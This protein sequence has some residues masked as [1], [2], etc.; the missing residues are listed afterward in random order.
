MKPQAHVFFS[1]VGAN[2]EVSSCL[3]RRRIFTPISND[4]SM[5][6][7][8]FAIFPG[9]FGK[10]LITIITSRACAFLPSREYSHVSRRWWAISAWTRTPSTL[11]V[12]RSSRR[13]YFHSILHSSSRRTCQH[14]ELLVVCTA[15][16]I[17]RRI[18]SGQ[19]PRALLRVAVRREEG[20]QV[21]SWVSESVGGAEH[22]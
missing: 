11:I 18:E 15:H 19:Q 14:W 9:A 21:E 4:Q 8:I 16:R 20:G 7:S 17:D 12:A 3:R 6:C 13:P 2:V 10:Q 5:T 1:H 22:A